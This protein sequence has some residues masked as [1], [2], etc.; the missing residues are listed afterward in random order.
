MNK[1]NLLKYSTFFFG[2]KQFFSI[3]VTHN[4]SLAVFGPNC[5]MQEKGNSPRKGHHH[6]RPT[7]PVLGVKW[8]GVMSVGSCRRIVCVCVFVCGLKVVEKIGKFIRKR[9][10]TLRTNTHSVPP[11]PHPSRKRRRKKE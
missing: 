8:T 5:L 10:T 7:K 6:Q 4:C 11:P 3:N 2:S 1:G 9:P